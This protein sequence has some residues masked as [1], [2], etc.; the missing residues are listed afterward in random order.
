MLEYEK[1]EVLNL[2]SGQRIET[3]VIKGKSG[4][5]VVC[6]NDRGKRG[7]APGPGDNRVYIMVE[8]KSAKKIKPKV[9]QGKCQKPN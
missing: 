1:V 9:V 5:G 4:S 7:F 6:L 3:Y 2:S 8:D